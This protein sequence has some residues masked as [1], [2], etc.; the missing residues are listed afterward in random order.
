M[1]VAGLLGIALAILALAV[2]AY[3]IWALGI[4][5]LML[6]AWLGALIWSGYEQIRAKWK[7]RSSNPTVA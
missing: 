4:A 5:I 6:F 3:A 1:L 7:R 2:A